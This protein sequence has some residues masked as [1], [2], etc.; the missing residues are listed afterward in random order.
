MSVVAG[1]QPLE[2]PET[3]VD[4]PLL[5]YGGMT[6]LD[7]SEDFR[8]YTQMGVDANGN[9][10]SATKIDNDLD[11]GLAHSFGLF[12]VSGR[13]VG[14]AAILGATAQAGC[15]ATVGASLEWDVP[16]LWYRYAHA[17][18]IGYTRR[19]LRVDHVLAVFAGASMYLVEESLTP[20]NAPRSAGTLFGAH[21]SAT[22]SVQLMP[23]LAFEFG[24]GVGGML[25]KSSSLV[26]DRPTALGAYAQLE[27]TVHHWD[28][29]AN[30]TLANLTR[31]A[32]PFW[33]AG[34]VHRW[35]G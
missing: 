22:A 10:T 26:D 18:G 2:Y 23:R 17:Q 35:G 13:A 34:V 6:S 25:T 4:R 33:S 24:A 30:F 8:T 29:Y 27:E 7:V 3:S 32:S 14:P 11:L 16:Q 28:F 15:D 31:S 19:L 12:Q 21:A 5:M 20:A 9:P 1:A